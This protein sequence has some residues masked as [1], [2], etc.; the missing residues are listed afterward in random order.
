MRS[1]LLI[2][3]MA[4]LSPSVSASSIADLTTWTLVQDPAHPGMTAFVDSLGSARL[5]A[6]G[7]VPSG[8][9]IGYAS[10]D[11]PDVASSTSGYYFDPSSSFS[12]AVDFELLT[13]SVTGVIGIGFGIGEDAAG[14]DSAGI[15]LGVIYGQ[16]VGFIAAGR[17][18][19]VGQPLQLFDVQPTVVS[20]SGGAIYESSGR[21]FLE[22]ASDTKS[23]SLGV[24]TTP[25]AAAP[26]ATQ[27]L[28]GFAAAWDGDPLLVSFLLRSQGD[29][30]FP[31]LQAGIVNVG[32]SNFEVL[33][34]ASITIPEPTTSILAILGALG[35]LEVKKRT[36]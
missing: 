24:S 1:G 10:I 13:R 3:A 28:S 4:S 7:P 27:T 22:Y 19:D 11:G 30:I 9:D 36:Y 32:F 21:F 34:G 8:T 16:P 2:L 17:V 15:T 12:V 5:S 23:V 31:E 35:V 33:S 6:N 20:S 26:T 25:G 29:E 14:K 18:D